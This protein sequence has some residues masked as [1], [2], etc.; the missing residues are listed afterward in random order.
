M[1]EAHG[2]ALKQLHAQL[3]AAQTAA[4]EAA[5]RADENAS[6]AELAEGAAAALEDRVKQLEGALGACLTAIMHVSSSQRACLEPQLESR[7]DA[8][9]QRTSAAVYRVHKQILKQYSFV[10]AAESQECVD[11]AEE[12]ITKLEEEAEKAAAEHT[13]AAA[14]AAAALQ[15]AAQQHAALAAERDAQLDAAQV[16]DKCCPD[17]CD[18]VEGGLIRRLRDCVAIRCL[19]TVQ[20]SAAQ[21]QA[22]SEAALQAE[23]DS[24]AAAAAA[25]EQQAEEARTTLKQCE[26]QRD[27]LALKVAQAANA[28]RNAEE[29]KEAK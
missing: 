29:L 3:A 9:H 23:R 5:A 2:E 24:A 17:F 27:G 7:G 11:A 18:A 13:A 19:W 4:Q 25:A 12:R 14:E 6:E 8:C 26:A 15:A 1:R 20:A 22:A 21:A 10:A 28:I 16:G